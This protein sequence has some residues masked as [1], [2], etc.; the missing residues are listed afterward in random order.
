MLKIVF[1]V[2]IV[3]S[4]LIVFSLSSN[5]K[6]PFGRGYPALYHSILLYFILS[7][8]IVTIIKRILLGLAPIMPAF[9]SLL[10][11]SYY[12]SNFPAKLMHP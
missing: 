9:C 4:K 1:K 11:L 12:S 3:C 5:I 8:A 10:L 7:I 6:Q 2:S